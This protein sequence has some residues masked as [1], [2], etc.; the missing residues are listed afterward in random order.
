MQENRAMV[1][2][3]KFKK[4]I[5]SEIFETSNY[6]DMTFDEWL[7]DLNSN[8][9]RLCGKDQQKIISSPNE[10]ESILKKRGR[11]RPKKDSKDDFICQDRYRPVAAEILFQEEDQSE[12]LK[13]REI[14]EMNK[15]EKNH[16][17]KLHQL[18]YSNLKAKKLMPPT[19]FLNKYCNYK[20]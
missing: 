17:Y 4:M 10:M 19:H 8:L 5:D 6:K 1:H 7:N 13:K 16:I 3:S 2:S 11:G 14:K 15:S 12:W 20:P 9:Q 18:Y